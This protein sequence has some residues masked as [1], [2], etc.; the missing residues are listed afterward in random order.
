M[1]R[2]WGHLELFIAVLSVY[3]QLEKV[4]VGKLQ[5]WMEIRGVIPEILFKT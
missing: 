3:N 1:I 2:N 5:H 4:T